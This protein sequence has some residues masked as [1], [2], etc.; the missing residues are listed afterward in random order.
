MPSIDQN[1]EKW[2]YKFRNFIE[3]EDYGYR[4]SEAWGGP[5]LMV[6]DNISRIERCLRNIFMK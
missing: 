1:I 5:F 2:D 6:L 3:D 4:W